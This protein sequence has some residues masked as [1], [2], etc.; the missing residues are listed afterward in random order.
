MRG[1][2]NACKNVELLAALLFTLPNNGKIWQIT[3]IIR[4]V[5][6]NVFR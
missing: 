5:S 6:Q 2:P 3:K 1:S 4:N